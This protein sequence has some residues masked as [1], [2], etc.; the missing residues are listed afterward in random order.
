MPVALSEWR[1]RIGTF[2]QHPP[3]IDKQE[4]IK[5]FMK[6]AKEKREKLA[7]KS[8]EEEGATAPSS[9]GDSCQDEPAP[10]AA[11]DGC[12]TGSDTVS[13]GCETV[14]STNQEHPA[15]ETSD[16]STTTTCRAGQGIPAPLPVSDSA[17]QISESCHAT[18][19][20]NGNEE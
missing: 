13:E 16:A 3:A 10:S 9:S 8:K 6:R 5:D 4:V 20:S 12:Q 15:A 1:A 19:T 7:G 18:S 11:K 14:S 17:V 2:I